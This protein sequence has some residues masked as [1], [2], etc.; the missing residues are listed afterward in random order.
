MPE[1]STSGNWDSAPR[2]PLRIENTEIE[3]GGGGVSNAT[4]ADLGTAAPG[5]STEASRADHVHDLP[6]AA[7]VGADPSGTAATAV[8]AHDGSG[9]AHA[10]IR[11]LI[12]AVLART[13]YLP[14]GL[15]TF[16]ATGS[17]A[18]LSAA[19]LAATF[20][21]P[22]SG[23]VE[24]ELDA[25]AVGGSNRLSWGVREG[26]VDLTD[27]ALMN[28]LVGPIRERVS[29]LV[30]GLTP[31]PH[32]LTWTQFG[33]GSTYAGTSGGNWNA[34]MT[35]TQLPVEG[36]SAVHRGGAISGQ[37]Y[38]LIVPPGPGPRPLI[39]YCHGR[40]GNETSLES[41]SYVSYIMLA[42]L[43]NAGWMVATSNGSGDAFGNAAVC[44]DF[45]ALHNWVDAIYPVSDVVM[46]GES[47]GGLAA[48]NLAG[49]TGSI[50]NMR[51]AMIFAGLTDLA[52]AYAGSGDPSFTGQINTAFGITGTT[53]N[54]YAEKTVGLDPMLRPDANYAGKRFLISTTTDSTAPSATHGAPLIAKLTGVAAEVMAPT[55]TGGHS[56]PNRYDDPAAILAFLDRC[57][58]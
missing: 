29:L 2:N 16:V 19:N 14:S 23:T 7:D 3:G 15:S 49:G 1:H 48:M 54:T 42:H 52:G 24:V 57:V 55:F 6:T 26:S 18:V 25:M 34:N 46:W 11:A 27:Q 9:A 35:V 56:S 22:E 38:R 40:G 50:P 10:D 36:V 44:N 17:L 12:P 30:T 4:P 32:T 5:V 58:S 39:M 20:T 31:G 37:N 8:T 43:L 13:S 28:A 41:V 53:P 33:T 47:M 45:A 51:G 21:A